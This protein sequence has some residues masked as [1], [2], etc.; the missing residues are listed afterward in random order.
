MAP[1]A[2]ENKVEVTPDARYLFNTIM[3]N[4][5]GANAQIPIMKALIHWY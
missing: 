1:A 2:K 5:A 3:T 4:I